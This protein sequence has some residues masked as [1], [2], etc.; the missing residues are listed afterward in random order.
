MSCGRRQARE[1]CTIRPTGQSI[2]DEDLIGVG[3]GNADKALSADSCDGQSTDMT[4]ISAAACYVV[5]LS[6]HRLKQLHTSSGVCPSSN[7]SFDVLVVVPDPPNSFTSTTIPAAM[8]MCLIY[9]YMQHIWMNS[10]CLFDLQIAP[11]KSFDILALYKMDYY[12]YYYYY[13]YY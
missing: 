5:L 11:R 7:V 8:V 6:L 10:I 1:W 12:Y 13:Y 2:T 3:D 9:T 4:A